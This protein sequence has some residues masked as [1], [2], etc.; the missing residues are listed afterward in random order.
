[1]RKLDVLRPSV[2]ALF[3]LIVGFLFACHGI[4]TLFGAFGGA[5]GADGGRVPVGQWPDGVASL[6]EVVT[7]VAVGL[8]LLTRIAATMASG[9]MAYVYFTVHQSN[10][11][12]PIQNGGE[13]AALFCWAFLARAVLGSGRYSMDRLGIR[14]PAG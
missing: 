2:L 11:L 14:P 8:G 9:V 6:I 1:M 7:G 4:A 10:G 13:S 12:L 5:F 3:R